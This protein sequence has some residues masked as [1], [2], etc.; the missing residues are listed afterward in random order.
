M[1]AARSERVTK[2]ARALEKTKVERTTVASSA[3]K[4]SAKMEKAQAA[5]KEKAK[6]QRKDAGTVEAHTMPRNALSLHHTNN[7]KV[8]FGSCAGYKQKTWARIFPMYF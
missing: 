8:R 7:R 4:V 6:D 1:A 5:A 2:A 3:V